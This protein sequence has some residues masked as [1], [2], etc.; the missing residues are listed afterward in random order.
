MNARPLLIL[1]LTCTVQLHAKKQ[2]SREVVPTGVFHNISFNAK[3][4]TVQ[5][6][7]IVITIGLHGY[8]L[9]FQDMNGPPGPAILVQAS[10]QW[11]ADGI[12]IS[13]TVPE[14]TPGGS[15]GSFH[16][17]ITRNSMVGKFDRSDTILK[18][19]RRSGGLWP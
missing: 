8:W 11:K 12:H 17:I 9:M 1:A 6:F 7:G 3:T 15:P 10:A 18:L 19:T 4:N 13:F 14:D 2:V 16:G 5:G